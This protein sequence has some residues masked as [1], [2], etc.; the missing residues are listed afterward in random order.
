MLE[1]KIAALAR[2]IRAAVE[3]YKSENR[4]K[5]SKRIFIRRCDLELRY[6]DDVGLGRF[7]H[8]RIEE[9]VWD[10]ADLQAFFSS[11]LMTLGEYKALA[12]ALG[13]TKNVNSSSIDNFVR[14]TA[15]GSYKGLSDENLMAYAT[16][17]GGELNGVVHLTAFIDGISISESPL[18]ISDWM[19]LHHPIAE[20]MA[21]Y[22]EQDGVGG[23]YGPMGAAFF[24]VIGEFFFAPSFEMAQ[25]HLLRVLAAL[26]LFR[27]GGVVSNRY[28]AKSSFLRPNRTV[29]M[30]GGPSTHFFTL[31]PSDSKAINQFLEDIVP[32][33]TGP[34]SEASAIEIANSRYT[35]A[36]FQNYPPEQVITST[37]T[38]LE[39]LF[40]NNEPELK[41]RLGQRV[42]IFLRLLGS[43][44][45]GYAT[46]DTVSKGYRIRS[47]FIHGDSL[48]PEDQP[49]ANR[50]VPMILE[51]ARASVLAFF[52][53]K[54]PK[55]ELL[56]QLDRAMVDPS[57]VAALES[58]LASVKHK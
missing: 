56:K 58:Q 33:I 34:G 9:D 50:I 45:D 51:Y 35:S 7:P 29:G 27:V 52:Q 28:S 42:S 20:D 37:V 13:E 49:E 2:A 11:V 25:D 40:L 4:V 39:A 3:K 57:S 36:I 12:A 55:N 38:A 46:Y 43:Q 26:R 53:L 19:V 14:A 21:E 16:K 1:D 31:S 23:F 24:R 47:K 6:V 18:A 10:P 44:P 22:V 8:Q 48:K 30:T 5:T 32:I 15:L 54:T 17:Y 41:H